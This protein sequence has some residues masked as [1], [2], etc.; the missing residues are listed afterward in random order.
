MRHSDAFS[1]KIHE[2]D[3]IGNVIT[4]VPAYIILPQNAQ[5]LQ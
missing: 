4:Y 1:L 2:I 3:K 5:L